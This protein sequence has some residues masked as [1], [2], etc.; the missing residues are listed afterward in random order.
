[1]GQRERRGCR[2]RHIPKAPPLPQAPSRSPTRA[3]A[4]AGAG[5]HGG[6]G[7]AEG[8]GAGLRGTPLCGC[9]L[10]RAL[11]LNGLRLEEGH[12]HVCACACVC[13][14]VYV[15]VCVCVCMCVCVVCTSVL[16]R[17][18]VCLEH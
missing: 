6:G 2:G 5:M 10:M 16:G 11:P 7:G 3:A 1:V 8:P 9:A 18:S 17:Q 14:Y 12:L 15:C 4:A 13:V